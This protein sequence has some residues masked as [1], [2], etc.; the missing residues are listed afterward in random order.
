M[1]EDLEGDVVALVGVLDW[2]LLNEALVLW[3]ERLHEM[4]LIVY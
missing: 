1:L 3:Q 4:A 2:A